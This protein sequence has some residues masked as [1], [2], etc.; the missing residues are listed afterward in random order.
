MHPIVLIVIASWLAGITAFFGG[1]I[2][3]FEGSAETEAKREM[4]HGIVAFGGGILLAAVALALVPKGIAVLSPV[5][6][7]L[8]FCCGRLLFCLLDAYLAK[9]G[10]TRAQFMAMLMD[11]LPEALSLGA[12]FGYD[13]RLGLLLAAFIGAQNLP[14]GFN[15]FREMTASGT[16]LCDTLVILCAASLLGPMAACIGYF[17]LQEQVRFTAA[18]MVFASGGIVY[19]IF[20]D[21]APQSKMRR[22]WLP[23]LGA[24]MGF[25]VGILGKMLIG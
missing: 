9:R 15:A 13:R 20:Q 22:H 12:V 8:T 19:L 2:A 11:F 14:E 17:F 16:R 6:L 18:I 24:V 25:A 7:T 3:W 1:L 10:G 4:I 5:N 23:P 21:I